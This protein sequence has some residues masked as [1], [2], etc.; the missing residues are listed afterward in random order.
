MNITLII[1]GGIVVVSTVPVILS[2]FSEMAKLKKDKA[3]ETLKYQKEILELELEREKIQLRLLEAED[4][5][6]DRIIY[7]SYR[8]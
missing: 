5:R 7:G 1:V 6:L 8:K 4:K 2:Y 3:L